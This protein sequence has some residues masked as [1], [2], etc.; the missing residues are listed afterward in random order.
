MRPLSRGQRKYTVHQSVL[1]EWL[2]TLIANTK[3]KI[4]SSYFSEVCNEFKAFI[5]NITSRVL[6]YFF[7][8]IPQ[9]TYGDRA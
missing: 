2:K 6:R 1:L 8:K 5:N 3:K 7:L 9:H 4:S